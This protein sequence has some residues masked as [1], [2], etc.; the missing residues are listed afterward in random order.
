MAY[1]S[2]YLKMR[3]C[4]IVLEK[5]KPQTRIIDLA[6]EIL[7]KRGE[8]MHYHDIFKEMENIRDFNGKT[9]KKSIYSVLTR[10]SRLIRVEKGVFK[11]KTEED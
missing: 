5:D 9:P 3:K 6:I 10:S 7:T 1:Q 2:V 8:P 4:A 11:L